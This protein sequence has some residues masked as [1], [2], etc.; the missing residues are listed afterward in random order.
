MT[1]SGGGSRAST[2]VAIAVLWRDGRVLVR[3]RRQ[4]ETL[5]GLWEFP[6][7]KVLA[8]ESPERAARREAREEMRVEVSG[9]ALLDLIEHDYPDRRV[10]ITV[11][12]GTCSGEPSP[13]DGAQWAWVT[14][15]ELASLPVPEANHGLVVRLAGTR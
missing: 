2:S 12:E 6:G 9:L 8:G 7:G 5:P 4:D 1:E 10:R 14:P 13:P 11:Y 3:Q 15:A